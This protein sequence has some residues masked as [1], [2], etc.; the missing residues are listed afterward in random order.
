MLSENL[1]NIHVTRE[2]GHLFEVM[3]EVVMNDQEDGVDGIIEEGVVWAK[4]SSS[5]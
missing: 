1:A 4:L 2:K 5:P 3:K